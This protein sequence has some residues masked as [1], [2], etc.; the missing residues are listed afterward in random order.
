MAK[1]WTHREADRRGMSRVDLI[2]EIKREHRHLKYLAFTEESNLSA[3]LWRDENPDKCHAYYAK[4]WSE[5]KD[6]EY[7]RTRAWIKLHPEKAKEYSHRQ[8][9]KDP[10]KTRLR[11]REEYKK[12]SVAYIRRASDWSRNNPAK[13][14]MYYD[15]REEW[16]S[17][18]S[19][20]CT[21]KI[22]LLKRERFCHWC[23]IQLTDNNRTIDHVIPL[24]RGGHHIPDNLI[25]CCRPCNCSKSNK[26][27]EE[28]TW[29]AA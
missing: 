22:E 8:R 5:D 17:V 13:K 24:S 9:T 7:Q 3:K 27:V 20:D 4:R 14:R 15:K 23:C 6:K 21:E 16:K 11:K 25:A 28:W 18:V 1:F 19:E 26:L 29:E 2:Q 12:H 10:E